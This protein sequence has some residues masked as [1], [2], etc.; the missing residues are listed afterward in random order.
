MATYHDRFKRAAINGAY[1]EIDVGTTDANG[2]LQFLTAADAELAAL[3]LQN[4]AFAAA[5]SPGDGT[6]LR[7][8][9]LPIA[10]DNTVTDGTI[11]KMRLR[12]RDNVTMVEYSV[13][14]VGGGGEVEMTDNVVPPGAEFVACSALAVAFAWA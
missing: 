1:D 7:Q 13:S 10:Q 6:S 8:A 3:Q 12:D 11:G 14:L 9:N 4:P 5:T 2:D